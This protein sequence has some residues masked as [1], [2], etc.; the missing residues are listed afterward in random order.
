MI[1]KLLS[2]SLAL[3]ALALPAAAQN[4]LC[5]DAP[6][7]DAS[8]R[9][10][11]T[12]FV[13]NALSPLST[14]S[15]P[16]PLSSIASQPSDSV[17]GNFSA[18][19]AALSSFTLPPCSGTN[20]AL[21]YN[22][23]THFWGCANTGATNFNQLTGFATVSQGG[24]GAS[25]FSALSNQIPVFSG[26]G[27]AAVANSAP[28]WFDSVYCNTVGWIIARTT[29]GWAC[30]QGIPAN[31]E[32]FG[33]LVSNSGATNL[34]NINSLISNLSASGGGQLL[35]PKV[36]YQFAGT[37][38]LTNHVGMYCPFSGDVTVSANLLETTTSS[39]LLHIHTGYVMI[40]NCTF[41]LSG[42]PTGSATG[43]KIGDDVTT[44]T[45]GAT[46]SG[47]TTLTCLTCTFTSGDVG[48]EFGVQTVSGQV[49][50]FTA[51]IDA[52]H[53]TTS[54]TLGTFTTQTITYG[55]NYQE[56]VIHD[57]AAYNFITG[58]NVVAATQYHIR[59]SYAVGQN[60]MVL[61]NA[62]WSDQGDGTVVENTL[63]AS[64]T[65]GSALLISSGGGLRFVNNK[66]LAQ[67]SISA[68]IDIAWT[69]VSSVGPWLFGNSI[70][71]TCSA[72][73]AI[74]GSGNPVHGGM[75]ISNEIGIGSGGT[76]I[77]GVPTTA[78]PNWI[79]N[80][81]LIR[82]TGVGTAVNLDKMTNIVVEGNNIQNVDSSANGQ[83]FG[84]TA[85]T[86]GTVRNHFC[87]ET[88]I[89]CAAASCPNVVMD[90][91]QGTGF[92]NI[93]T[94][95]ANG[96]RIFITNG[97]PASS[98]CTGA[99]TGSTAFRQNGAWKCF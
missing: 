2:A 46:A 56:V 94:G 27:G 53:M 38:T 20:Q 18:S 11:N 95:A 98:P 75:I 84:M 57:S 1:R 55:F 69:G 99:S 37:L 51:F 29:G 32:W 87:G 42:S 28:S 19:I 97:A 88:F 31:V 60:P 12:R 64:T 34:T 3:C 89:M 47:T 10:A 16:I 91:Q 82:Q 21:N 83:C 54:I 85:N 39:D 96:S 8:N 62:I 63:I 4:T 61:G 30:A 22:T 80:S 90:D 93:P 23:T 78:H 49:G 7:G 24:L 15:F 50:T 26:G 76:G 44:V 5:S 81:N 70:E 45:N 72:G 43:I 33:V 66:V 35:F 41:A 58:I 17:L 13:G 77:N 40:E 48:K 36:G 65:G 6:N 59:H 52:N 79:I 67:A 73:I 86:T 74:N 68:C 14:T 71:G 9:C 92:A 25:Q